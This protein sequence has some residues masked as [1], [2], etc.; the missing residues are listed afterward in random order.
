MPAYQNSNARS[1]HF[2]ALAKCQ[3]RV[4]TGLVLAAVAYTLVLLSKLPV[5]KLS[6]HFSL[7]EL[8]ASQTATRKNITEQFNPPPEIIDNLKSLYKNLLE[9]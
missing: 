1:T 2:P 3:T 6:A 7:E 5:M 8:L 9:K 4:K